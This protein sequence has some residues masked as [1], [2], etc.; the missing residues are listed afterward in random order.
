MSDRR[1]T[2]TSPHVP[3]VFLQ[4]MFQKYELSEIAIGDLDDSK[5]GN[6]VIDLEN[7][8]KGEL[9]PIIL[10]YLS[11]Y[12]DHDLYD[13]DLFWELKQDSAG[14]HGKGNLVPLKGYS[15]AIGL[16]MA[17]SGS[18]PHIWTKEEI[19]AAL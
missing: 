10:T 17:I 2:S 3:S 1:I 15:D 4:R 18:E 12:I 13:E 11:H 19:S 5:L 14:S 7:T 8:S 6:T 16:E 9:S